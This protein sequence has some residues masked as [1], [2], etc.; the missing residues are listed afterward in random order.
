MFVAYT[1]PSYDASLKKLSLAFQQLHSF[2]NADFLSCESTQDNTAV[3]TTIIV[4]NAAQSINNFIEPTT[5]SVIGH[6]H[7]LCQPLNIASVLHQQLYKIKLLSRQVSN[8]AKT[9]SSLN[10]NT[11]GGT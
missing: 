6:I 3:R 1:T 9:K 2:F 10:G 8:P 5:G 11:T 7:L 4:R